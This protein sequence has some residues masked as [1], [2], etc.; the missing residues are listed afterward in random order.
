MKILISILFSFI[1]IGCGASGPLYAVKPPKTG[2]ARLVICR[3]PGAGSAIDISHVLVDKKMVGGLWRKSY[4]EIDVKPGR[5][6][7]IVYFH[8]NQKPPINIPQ[9]VRI[10]VTLKANET[11]YIK[12]NVYVAHA[13]SMYTFKMVADLETIKKE[14]AI[15]E[16]SQGYKESE[17]FDENINLPNNKWLDDY[18]SKL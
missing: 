14:K 12:Y 2:K 3:A 9:P 4:I 10:D 6:S 17:Y 13:Y 8:Q 7:V 5:H 15:K 11:K 1:L 16:L 18:I